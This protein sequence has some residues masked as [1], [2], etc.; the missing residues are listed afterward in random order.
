ML[1]YKNDEHFDEHFEFVDIEMIHLE[2]AGDSSL[3][4]SECQNKKI[5]KR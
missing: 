2:I 1:Q 5:S 3:F 4:S